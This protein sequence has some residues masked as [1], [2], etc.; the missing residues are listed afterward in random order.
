MVNELKNN[1][2]NSAPLSS[3]QRLFKSLN[4]ETTDRPPHFE[5]EFQIVEEA[6]GKSY[7]TNEEWRAAVSKNEREKIFIRCAEI[8]QSIINTFEW[9]ALPVV[10]GSHEY[11]FYPFLKKVLGDDIPI[12]GMIWESTVS[13]ET[14]KD[15]EQ[16][17]IDIFENPEIIH[18][19][20]RKL[21]DYSLDRL[22]RLIDAGCDL[23]IVP[24]DIAYNQGSFISPEQCDE[25][26]FQYLKELF[27]AVHRHSI[28]VIFHTDGN[29][30]PVLDQIISIGPDCLQS[31]DPLAG[32]DI[33]EVKKRTYKKI[34][35]MGNVDC[36]ALHNGPEEKIIESAKYALDNA[37]DGGGYIFSSSNT[38]FKGVP[39][40]HYKLMLDYF[41]DRF[42]INKN[43]R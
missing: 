33:K 2:D 27:D 39:L 36:G 37:V 12:A 41:H 28:P 24:S 17:S 21:M 18:A 11:D 22:N 34:A 16:F 32:M 35:L 13:I 6:F 20:A 3:R 31:I 8:Y 29:L 26:I 4:F 5:L 19:R 9:D 7:P 25:F 43:I 15:Y 14:I 42:N 38:I 10:S 30:M 23:I 1:P 40:N